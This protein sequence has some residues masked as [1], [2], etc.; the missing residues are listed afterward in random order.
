MLRQLTDHPVEEAAPLL[1]GCTLRR[2]GMSAL[3]VEV[4]AYGGTNQDPAS[5]AF[6]GQTP[7]NAAMFGPAGHAYV[8]FTYGNHWMLNVSCRPIGEA[9][10]ILIRAAM[11]VSGIEE[12]YCQRP[13]AKSAN[14]LLSGPGKLCQAFGIDRSL[15][16]CDLFAGNPELSIEIGQPL[17][18]VTGPR[19]GIAVGKGHE[20]R[21]RFCTTDYLEWCSRPRLSGV[22]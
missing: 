5:H 1:L 10:A 12:M 6:R 3:I 18:F 16:G 20:T 7:R 4:E 19:V 22:V 9:G 14:D 15:D 2:R 13:A 21:W 8:Y 11:P 17:P